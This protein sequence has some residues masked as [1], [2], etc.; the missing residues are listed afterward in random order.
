MGFWMTRVRRA[1]DEFSAHFPSRGKA[2]NSSRLPMT[3]SAFG[4]GVFGRFE[5][6]SAVSGVLLRSQERENAAPGV[7]TFLEQL[8]LPLR[9]PSFSNDP[10][11]TG[12]RR[13]F[14]Q[15]GPE[16]FDQ[17]PQAE[18]RHHRDKFVEHG[19]LTKQRMSAF[20]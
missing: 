12:K 11:N 16:A 14:E 8:L 19:S 6:G 13:Q 1:N 15:H 5:R 20:F 3:A 10:I 17:R 7:R 18:L 2:K 9:I 4:S